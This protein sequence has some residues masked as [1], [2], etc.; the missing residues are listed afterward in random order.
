[1][2]LLIVKNDTYQSIDD[3]PEKKSEGATGLDVVTTSDPNIVGNYILHEGK[4]LYSEIDYIEYKTNLYTTIENTQ[5][6]FSIPSILQI[7]H[8]ILVFPRSSVSKYKLLLANSI[9]LIDSDYRGE[10]I[11]RF[12]YQWQPSDYIIHENKIYGIPDMDKIY[13]KDDA[14]CQLKITKVEHVKIKLVDKLDATDRGEGGFGS[15]DKQNT[16]YIED[17]Y[18]K[19]MAENN[20][21]KKYSELI[22]EKVIQ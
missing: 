21:P 10:I 19:S 16:S 12:K 11:L 5:A 20:T 3:V 8:D 15:T 13:K 14:I 6:A 22:K 2:N 4:K 7:N 18:S 1:M 17:I 9:G